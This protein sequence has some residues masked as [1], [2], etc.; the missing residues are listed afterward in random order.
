VDPTQ[1]WSQWYE[2]GTKLWNDV[3]QGRQE[4]LVDPYGLFRQWFEGMENAREMAMGSMGTTNPLAAMNP[5]S[6]PIAGLMQNPMFNP[7][8][9]PMSA[10]MGTTGTPAAANGSG[11]GQ[12]S[13][14]AANVDPGDVWRKWFEAT[15]ESWQKSADLG[16]EILGMTPRWMQMMAQSR[17]N[18]MAAQSFPKDPLEFAVQWY[19]ATS[20]PLSE[21]VHDVIEREEFLAQSSRFMR[22]YA[23]LYKIFRRNSE[24]YLKFYQ[25]PVRSDITRVASLIIGLEDKV[26]RIEEAFEDFEYGYAQPATAEAVES[27]DNRLTNVQRKLND[28]ARAVDEAVEALDNRLTSVQRRLT[29][30]ANTAAENAEG[31]ATADAVDGLASRVDRMEGK[32]D[33]VEHKL[34]QLL[35]ALDNVARNGSDDG[36][37]AEVVRSSGEQ[38]SGGASEAQGEIKATDAARRKAAEIGVDLA[39]VEGTGNDGQITVGDVR[40]KGES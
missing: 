17:D 18:M 6:N 13:A 11:E 39:T 9:N 35:S 12:G 36:D 19:N 16:S 29:E 28:N 25:L 2:A 1:L 5:A 20:G 30:S 8:F 4:S 26:D 14:L 33:R 27:L 23:S 22:N 21:F 7:M 40:Q 10:I 34:D 32:I 15:A 37:A 38:T 3:V 24:E 31:V